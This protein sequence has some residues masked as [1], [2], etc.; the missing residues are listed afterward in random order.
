MTTISLNSILASKEVPDQT[1]TIV[2]K[3]FFY[4]TLMRGVFMLSS[5]FY[6]LFIL[7]VVGIANASFLITLG[8]IIQ[9]L[10]DYPSGAFGDKIGHKN[11][12]FLSYIIHSIVFASLI[13]INSF[14]L[15]IL[16][17]STEALARSLE[18]GALNSWF[19][20]NYKNTAMEV[21][22]NLEVYKASNFRMEMIL[23]IITS[24]MFVIGGAL[25]YYYNRKL[26]FFLQS[27]V[28]ILISI[29][30]ATTLHDSN[31]K[32]EK[33]QLSYKTVLTGGLNVL[34]K[35]PRLMV[36]VGAI[37]VVSTPLA[38]WSELILFLLYFGYTGSD[39]MAGAFRFIVWFASSL[40]VGLV[41][42]YT[43]K[44]TANKTLYK[45]HLIHP[46]LF[47]FSFAILIILYPIKNSFDIIA[48]VL[49][50][51]IFSLA[52]IIHNSS[53][54]LTKTVY[55]ELVPNDKRNSFYSLVPTLS[56]LFTGP[57][58]YLFGFI[59]TTYG[60]STTILLLGL[61]ELIGAVVL[62]LSFYVPTTWENNSQMESINLTQDVLCCL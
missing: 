15:L 49:A 19:D 33:E 30:I 5:T 60:L 29:L 8:F 46:F 18:S 55:L 50:L 31:L 20:N 28:M 17:Y 45:M 44:Y 61:V 56:M 25:A 4:S 21:D 40:M 32:A 14:A 51:V 35:S 10:T 41:G 59:I 53:D 57:L 2:K 12:I 43:K 34:L 23:G 26:V 36:F 38:I 58:I 22:K 24:S 1:Q 16:V 9:G 42:K 6:F 3:Y 54:I 13:F 37:I 62:G 7:D 47:F 48:L 27:L 52:G 11:I 39:A